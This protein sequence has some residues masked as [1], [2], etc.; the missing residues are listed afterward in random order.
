MR[1][2][3]REEFWWLLGATLIFLAAARIFLSDHPLILAPLIVISFG[4]LHDIGRTGWV[5]LPA[6]LFG[7]MFSVGLDHEL[8]RG[9]GATLSSLVET[10]VSGAF[11]VAFFLSLCAIPGQPGTNRF[12]PPP[13]RNRTRRGLFNFGRR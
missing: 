1:R 5:A 8:G 11:L 6:L 12:G 2:T 7:I 9:H 13:F 4:R 3:S 10:L